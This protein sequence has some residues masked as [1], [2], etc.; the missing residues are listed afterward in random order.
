MNVLTNKSG[1]AGDAKAAMDFA[2]MRIARS[3]NLG[4]PRQLID[5]S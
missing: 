4:K 5:K 2:N 3:V 1:L